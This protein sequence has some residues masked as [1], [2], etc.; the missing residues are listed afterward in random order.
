MFN[1]FEQPWT[2]LGAAIITLLVILIVR[3]IFPEKQRWWLW[4]VPVF[5]A[6]AGFALDYLVK[7]DLEKINSLI[8]AGM[9]AVEQ[10]DTDAIDAMIAP[11]YSDSYHNTKADLMHYCNMMLSQPLVEKNSKRALEIQISPAQATATLTALMRFDKQSFVCQTGI[12]FLPIKV[13]L[14]VQK[15]PDKNWLFNRAEVLELNGQPV[16]WRHVR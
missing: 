11:D 14:T 12:T 8:K 9:K 7:T 5:I 6:V 10:E 3:S 13:E 1:I 16:N 2:L 4:L 15:Q